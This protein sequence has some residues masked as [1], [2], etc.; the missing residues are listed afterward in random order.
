M[1]MKGEKM[2]RTR[3]GV[4]GI[5]GYSRSHIGQ[6]LAAQDSGQPVEL[7]AV[8]AYMR[9]NN[10]KLALEL[11]ARGVKLRDGYEELL[12]M[13]D[14]L[15]CIT[16]PVGIPLHVPMAARALEAGFPVYLEKPVTGAIQDA[17]ALSMAEKASGKKLFIGYQLCFQPII[18]ELK[19]KLLAGDIGR[20]KKM[21][22]VAEWPRSRS[23]FNRNQWAGKLVANGT[24]V[25]DSPMNNACAHYINLALFLAG[26]EPGK[27]AV[28]V[29]V[30]AELYRANEIESAD[31]VSSRIITGEG[32]EI[33]WT[34]SHACESTKGPLIRIE[35]EK[36]SLS[37]D[38]AAKDKSW[39]TG[40]SMEGET[41]LPD[42]ARPVNPF[43]QVARWLKG[44]RDIPVCGIEIARA[45]TLVVNG[46]H[47]AA[48]VLKIPGEYISENTRPDGDVQVSVA[49]M[50]DIL[51]QCYGKGCMIS[52]TGLA[53]WSSAPSETDVRNLSMLEITDIMKS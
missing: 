4:V 32:V 45:Q 29:S 21:V 49:G 2:D 18:W 50:N 6:I 13:K 41:F 44:E 23:Y 28:P 47:K 37:V 31:T 14:S 16:L 24:I 33:V 30:Q 1:N 53:K 39:K 34:A 35:G 43:V 11:E 46:V 19:R 15:D 8:L 12:A 38:Y 25:L 52:E 10:E 9:Q 22:V 48:S 7:T 36:K 40:F 27:S 42:D 17:D 5:M 3:F 20:V 26:S 51:D